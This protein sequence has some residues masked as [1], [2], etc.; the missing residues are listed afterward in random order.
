MSLQ[1]TQVG[2]L[3]VWCAAGCGL[4]TKCCLSVMTLPLLLL[5]LLQVAPLLE[6]PVGMALYEYR[7][8]QIGPLSI[9]SGNQQWGACA[10]QT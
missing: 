5:L 7:N 10:M 8:G 3:L 6:R 9:Q 1:E 4:A 2:P